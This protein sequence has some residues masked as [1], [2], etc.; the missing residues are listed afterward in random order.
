M[1]TARTGGGSTDD[2]RRR[3]SNGPERGV[4]DADRAA[5][6]VDAFA[7]AA[8]AAGSV[9]HRARSLDEVGALARSL[10]EGEPVLV[11]T[12]VA[13]DE[14]LARA[15]GAVLTTD[16]AARAADRP[17]AVERGARPSPRPARCWCAS[18]TGRA[19]WP[20]C[21]PAPSSRSWPPRTSSPSLD[22]AGAWLAAHAGDGYAALITGP[23]RT[24]DIE[25]VITVGVQGPARLHVVLVDHWS[26]DATADGGATTMTTVADE[27][28]GRSAT[29][30]RWTTRTCATGCSPSSG[31]GASSATSS[32]RRSTTTTGIAFAALRQQMGDAK[33]TARADLDATL[34]RFRTRAEAAGTTVTT[35][36][37]ADD[38]CEAVA[39]LCRD[40]GIDLVVKGKSMVSEEI[41]L[42]D[43]LADAR[44]HRRRDRP[45]RVADPARRRAPEP[46]GPPRRSTSAAARSPRCSPRSSGGRSTPRTSPPWWR[47][48]GPS[49]ATGSS[50]PAWASPAPTPSSPRPAP[51]CW[52]RTRATA[53]SPPRCP[54]CT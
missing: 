44:H 7:R 12:E 13:A 23:S 31:R 41:E 5:S 50:A 43:H 16:D 34:D 51:R 52:S 48:S 53:A 38:A 2:E 54:A 47:W 36:A 8:E 19:G 20:R 49:C 25:R 46:P 39:R 4:G 1:S 14:V 24:A 32:S 9:V 22:D 17:V 6:L 27:A 35:A 37:T 11:T 45:R 28:A 18:P 3:T 10:G 40:R 15:L 33:R 30:A 26:V 29:A 42:N 21:W